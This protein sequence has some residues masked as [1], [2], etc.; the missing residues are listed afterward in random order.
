MWTSMAKAVI[1]SPSRRAVAK[2]ITVG[3]VVLKSSFMTTGV[4]A[5][6]LAGKWA[7][8]ATMDG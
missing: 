4:T 1:P 2:A 5:P 6:A 3:S 7:D 8:T